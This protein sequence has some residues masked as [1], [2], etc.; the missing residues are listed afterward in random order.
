MRV[1]AELHLS[2]RGSNCVEASLCLWV[3]MQECVCICGCVCVEVFALYVYVCVC[4]GVYVQ[5]CDSKYLH[6]CVAYMCVPSM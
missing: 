2:A 5:L 6:T 1:M 4:V 3:H